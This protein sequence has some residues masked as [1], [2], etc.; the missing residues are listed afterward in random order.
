MILENLF[1]YLSNFMFIPEDNF[2]FVE[3]KTLKF[4]TVAVDIFGV[5][6]TSFNTADDLFKEN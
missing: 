4:D 3:I 2:Q 5:D 6:L 1:H